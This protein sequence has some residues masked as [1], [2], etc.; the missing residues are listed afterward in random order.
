MKETTKLLLLSRQLAIEPDWD[1]FYRE[2][3]PQVYNFFLYRTGNTQL[4]EDLASETFE[5][6]WSHR[7][8]YRENQSKLRTWLFGIAR[9]VFLE[10]LRANRRINHVELTKALG[11][12]EPENESSPI[13]SEE[14]TW[15]KAVLDNLPAREQE[16]ISLKFC[17]ALTN[18]EISIV[19]RLSESNVGTI[20]MRTLQK[21]RKQKED[22]DGR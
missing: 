9:N 18:R 10:H 19:A 5:R 15:L 3:L 16:L 17:A 8:K 7:V 14:S 12:S 13:Q 21:I 1:G 6:T 2:T 22:S 11:D 20:L 4:A